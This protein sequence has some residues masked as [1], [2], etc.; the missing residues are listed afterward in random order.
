MCLPDFSPP[1]MS[2]MFAYTSDSPSGIN[3]WDQCLMA[4]IISHDIDSNQVSQPGS[5]Q[6]SKQMVGSSEIILCVRPANEIWRY[7]VTSSLIG[8]VHTQNDPWIHSDRD[9]QMTGLDH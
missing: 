3:Q 7:I 9:K 4:T 5:K 6:S 8:Q 1:D 2:V